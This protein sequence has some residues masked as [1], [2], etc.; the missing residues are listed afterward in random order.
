MRCLIFKKIRVW[1]VPVFGTNIEAMRAFDH[2]L[3]SAR[4]DP[5]STF[6]IGDIFRFEIAA[7]TKKNI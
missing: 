6:G 1:L 3:V 5:P 7:T 2:L 4:A